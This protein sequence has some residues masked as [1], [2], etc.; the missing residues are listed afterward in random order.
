MKLD[1]RH[2]I[3]KVFGTVTGVGVVASLY[4]MKRTWDPLPG[5]AAAGFTTLDMT[6]YTKYNH[7]YMEV[8]RGKPIFIIKKSTSMLK[9]MNSARNKYKKQDVSRD[10]VIDDS[11]FLMCIGICTH[12]GCIP[13]YRSQYENFACACHGAMYDFSGMVT[14]PP[15]PRGFD[16]P[17]F[18]RNG[19]KLILGLDSP[20][21][22]KLVKE[23]ATLNKA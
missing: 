20:E 11:H 16:I 23:H 3:E 17:P 13:A 19:N 1:R 4:A 12:L 18:K 22:Q 10:I 7:L 21:Y 2:F 6:K 8:W 9:D 5:I 14:K 15:A